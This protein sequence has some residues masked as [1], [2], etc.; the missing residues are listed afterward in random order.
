M[1]E[2]GTLAKLSKKES[3]KLNREMVKLNKNLE[4]I[5]AMDKLP[6]AIFVIDAKKEDIAVKEARKLGIPVVALVDTN[7]DPDLIDYVIPGND[8]AIRSIKL[9][10]GIIAD[11]I[12]EGKEAFVA[13]EL[14]AREEAAAAL[15]EEEEEIKVVD[16]KIEE[17]VAGDIKLKEDEELPKDVPIKR[18]K[19]PAK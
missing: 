12:Q 3:A 7:S 11:T 8:D 15:G 10:T 14:K 9:V 1:K 5:R 6:R 2:D 19:K 18:K 17:L 16:E 13:G 4:G